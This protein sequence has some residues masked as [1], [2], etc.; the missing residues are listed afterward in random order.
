MTRDYVYE[1]I[2]RDIASFA[3]PATE[4]LVT[5]RGA[6]WSQMRKLVAVD[7]V[8]G[9]DEL[10]DIKV[11]NLQLRYREF[12]A[13][14][15]MADIK[16]LAEGTNQELGRQGKYVDV[17]AR[18]EESI[19]PKPALSLLKQLA[20]EDLP[21]DATRLV[22]VR[23]AAGAGKTFTLK[24]LASKQAKD[25]LDG[26]ASFLFFYIDAQG[27]ALSRLDEAIALLLH[28]LRAR[29]TYH[30]VAT[31]TRLGILVPIIDGFDELL[32]TGGYGEAFQ[33][34]A[35][36]LAR[37][38][39]RGSVIA[40]AR[41]TFYEYR[42]FGQSASKY[43]ELGA[44]NF[45][46]VPADF[47]P[48]GP[49]QLEDYLAQTSAFIN[50]NATTPQ[51]GL[52]NLY[53]I[54]GEAGAELLESPFF[55]TTALNI[56]EEGG[57]FTSSQRLVPQLVEHFIRR[58][59]D[60][61]KDKTGMPILDMGGHVFILQSLAEEMWWQETREL[62]TD[63]V[64][65][66]AE[67]ACEHLNIGYPNA[68]TIIERI[69]A[70]AFLENR[71]H[72]GRQHLAFEHEYYYSYFLGHLIAQMVN[73]KGDL[74]QLLSR[75]TLPATVGEEFG[76]AL[77]NSLKAVQDIL[78]YLGTRKT[79]V[80]SKEINRS[81]TGVL[82][83]G[84]IRARNGKLTDASFQQADLLN[85]NL[86]HTKLENCLFLNC[87][88]VH[89]D[90]LA[91]QWKDV[92]FRDCRLSNPKFDPNTTR[93]QGTR[94]KI[95]VDLLGVTIFKGDGREEAFFDPTICADWCTKVGIQIIHEEPIHKSEA[96]ASEKARRHIAVFKKVLRLAGR[97]FYISD[98]D[99][100]K[101]GISGTHEW[102]TLLRLL[103][104]HLLIK[105]V[106]IER[107][108]PVGEV[109]R[110]A[111][112]PAEFEK[113]EAGVTPLDQIRDFWAELKSM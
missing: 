43:A 18:Q 45:E 52:R 64:K 39:G 112:P 77:P 113:G 27:R 70:Y 93:L 36:F 14:E 16:A 61:L 6:T 15:H 23:G 103:N 28:D 57:S 98:D 60:K 88:L 87:D 100:S 22:F 48:W 72:E 79:P 80:I 82:Y 66:I 34:L 25:V 1:T 35:R 31:L 109:M 3:D 2:R 24:H 26:S 74:S 20:A 21:F 41:S 76:F 50:L 94:L 95:G 73:E 13:S 97:R 5:D 84:I 89:V 40:S 78:S 46:I 75:S 37:L 19:E 68:A 59:M 47:L 4:V 42:S 29:F 7:F 51:E 12:F 62:D 11:G 33:S 91:A 110:L 111:I 56:I 108:G 92:E 105:T 67:I 44:L 101:A 63:T 10:P 54:I 53:S 8:R 86:G 90:L 30:A 69:P 9:D 49:P 71:R 81:N 104:S 85:A 106:R 102:P 38:D 65:T 99:L 32:G 55:V 17:L 96:V 83:A 107:R 58:E